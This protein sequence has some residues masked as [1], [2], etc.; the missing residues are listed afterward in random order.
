[1]LLFTCKHIHPIND[2]H[3][4]EDHRLHA[5]YIVLIYILTKEIGYFYMK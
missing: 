5:E 2:K 1:M 3:R 4:S